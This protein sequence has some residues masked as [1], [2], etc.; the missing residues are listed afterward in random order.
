[1]ESESAAARRATE[2]DPPTT[3]RPNGFAKF[4][5][6]ADQNIVAGTLPARHAARIHTMTTHAVATSPMMFPG[7]NGEVGPAAAGGTIGRTYIR[8]VVAAEMM[9]TT[10]T[11]ASI[12]L[13]ADWRD[14]FVIR[15]KNQAMLWFGLSAST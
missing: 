11:N 9:E 2:F 5:A 15:P 1:M 14:A 3:K 10:A 4:M 13:T 12:H 7:D 8:Q 6:T